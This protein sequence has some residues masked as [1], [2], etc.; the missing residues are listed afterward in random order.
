MHNYIKVKKY[1]LILFLITL[2]IAAIC[3]S[4]INNSKG[5]LCATE[6]EKECETEIV[7][8]YFGELSPPESKLYLFE[9]NYLF[10]NP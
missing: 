4:I 1:M 7:W 2:G 10:K 6:N 3:F 9:E 5:G 8:E